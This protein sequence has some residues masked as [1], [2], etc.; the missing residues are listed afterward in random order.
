MVF[1]FRSCDEQLT[2]T[3]ERVLRTPVS[4]ALQ[5]GRGWSLGGFGLTLNDGN[6]VFMVLSSLMSSFE[7][8]MVKLL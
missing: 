6:I 1:W 7:E 2:S 5:R 8:I 4:A 3:G